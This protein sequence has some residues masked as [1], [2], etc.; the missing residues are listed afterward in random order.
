[1][2]AEL[3]YKEGDLP[4]T[5]KAALEVISLPMFPELKTEQQQYV[6]EKIREFYQKN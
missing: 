6:V 4:E 2:F 1:V 3:G 5:E